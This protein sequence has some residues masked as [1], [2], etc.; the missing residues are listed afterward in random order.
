MAIHPTA[1]IGKEVELA[2]D[3]EVGPYVVIEGR[4]RIGRGVRIF[5]HAYIA[6]CT[7][8]ADGCS[9]HPGAVVGGEPQD[10]SFE[11]GESFCR[12]GPGTVVREGAQ[13]HRGVKPGSETVVGSKCYLMANSHVAHNCRLGNDV[14]LANCALLAPEQGNGDGSANPL[15]QT[16]LGRGGAG[17]RT[18]ARER[19]DRCRR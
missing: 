11:G 16:R 18:Q 8:I 2:G 19:K 6:G 3:V 5:P 17:R 4:V 7:E 13:V 14:I 9:I 12:I 15:G 10:L 1:I